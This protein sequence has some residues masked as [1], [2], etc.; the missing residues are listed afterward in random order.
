MTPNAASLLLLPPLLA[1]ACDPFHCMFEEVEP[2]VMY[3]AAQLTA[4]P[5]EAAEL[6]V[7]TW[8]I[9][10]GGGRI[11]FFWDCYDNRTV[12]HEDEVLENLEALAEKIRLAEPDVLFTSETD[13]QGKRSAYVDQVQWILD[14]TEFNYAAYA[15]EWKGDIIP[16]DGFG[17][18]NTGN[19]IFS[20]WPLSDAT[21]TSLPLI[22][23]Q[24]AI[25]TYFYIKTNMLRAQ[26]DLPWRDDVSVVATHLEDADDATKGE[27]L[28]L[29]GEEVEAL[30]DAGQLVIAGGDLNLVP[31]GTVHIVGYEDYVCDDGIFGAEDYT[32]E[33]DWL[34]P[35]YET[36]DF[37]IPLDDYQADNSP[38]FTFTADEHGWW[39]RKLDYLLTNGTV[40]EGSGLTHQD[41]ASGGVDTL[42]LSDHAPLSFVVEVGS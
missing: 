4:V 24:D 42:P 38:H 13:V 26:L 27:S 36:Y 31:P 20:R 2:A 33:L 32:D 12:M 40:V 6:T 39:S 25:T 19:A 3:E 9:K 15:S 35:W 14:N 11:G 7:M 30:V 5:S 23:D 18:E 21:R 17:R 29:F 34:G 8:N 10:F 16:T 1:M 41:A 22:E 28:D 37:A